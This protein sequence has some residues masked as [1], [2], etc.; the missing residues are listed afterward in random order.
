MAVT[1]HERQ[2]HHDRADRFL[3]ARRR[4]RRRRVRQHRPPVPSGGAR[5]ARR[6]RRRGVLVP[7]AVRRDV[8]PARVGAAEPGPRSSR[9]ARL[10]GG[11]RRR[12]ARGD[13]RAGRR[14]TSTSGTATTR[15]RPSSRPTL[16]AR[17]SGSGSASPARER[18]A[19]STANWRHVWRERSRSGRSMPIEP[20]IAPTPP[21][22]RPR[23][24]RSAS[25]PMRCA[26]VSRAS[27]PSSIAATSWRWSTASGSWTTRRRRTCTPRSPRSTRSPATPGAV[28][29]AGG[30]AKGVDLSPLRTRSD[31]LAGVVA[32]GESADEIA[33]VVRRADPGAARR[34]DR[35]RDG[36]GVRARRR[37][38][39]RCCWRPACASWDMFRDY[40]ER[41]DRF[42]A[43]ARALMDAEVARG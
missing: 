12:E 9:L 3:P 23:R 18:S 1:G 4:P 39:A 19:T 43:A 8:P 24:W 27:R 6:A 37:G 35:G 30:R 14:M 31:R 38:R 28:L 29:I 33:S 40:A 34:L 42:A 17:W 15:R 25:R 11:V 26:A 20:A 21:P 41:G 13:A 5:G 7:A 16:P 10:G 22:P 2:D 32:I 36:R